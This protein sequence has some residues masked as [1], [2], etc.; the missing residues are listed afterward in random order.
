MKEQPVIYPSSNVGQRG[1][2]KRCG[3]PMVMYYSSLPDSTW[4][5]VGTLDNPNVAERYMI[6]HVCV[7]SEIS[8]LTIHDNLERMRSD[9]VDVYAN[10]GLDL[11]KK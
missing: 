5:Y 6:S 11:D 10:A 9:E 3:S 4:I 2:C 7:E 8:W 1:F